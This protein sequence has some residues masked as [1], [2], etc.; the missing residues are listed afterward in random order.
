MPT[1]PLPRPLTARPF[2]VSLIVFGLAL[3]WLGGMLVS[4][5]G[6]A[7][8]LV[9]GTATVGSGLLAWRGDRRGAYLYAAMLVGTFVWA[10]GEVGFDPWPLMPRLLAPIVLG[11]GFPLLGICPRLSRRQRLGAAG[12]VVVA[13]ALV[14]IM[15][16]RFDPPSVDRAPSLQQRGGE[17]TEAS[18]WPAY[19]RDQG[20]TRYS[21]LTQLTPA[22]VSA[23]QP[24]WQYRTGYV[25]ESVRTTFEATPLKIGDSLYF[26]SPDNDIIALDATTGVQRWRYRM[27]ADQDQVF[28]AAC[29]GVTYFRNPAQQGGLCTAAIISGTIDGRLFALDAATGTPCPRFGRGGFVDLKA[30]LGRVEKGYYFVTSAPQLI[31]GKVVLGGWVTDNQH[32]GEPSGVIRAFDAATGAFAWA[33][34]MGRPNDHGMP[35]AGQR[36]TPGT[37]NSW[38]P[39][40]ADETLGLVYLPTGNA[41]PD[42]FGGMRRPFDEKY[43][44]SVVALNADTGAV[45][46]SFQT[47]HHDLWDYDVPSQPTL[48]DMPTPSGRVPAVIQAT[49][50]GEIF[51]LDRR[52]GRPITRVEERPA[53]KSNVPGER[54]APTQPFSTGMP[55]FAGPDLTEAAMWG[56]TPLDQAW[57]RILFRR[58]RYDGPVTPVGL[59]RPTIISPGYTGGMNWGGVSIDRQRDI[60]IVNSMRVAVR[61]QLIPR[62]QADRLGVKAIS[63]D[64][65]GDVG[66]TAAQAG[67][68]YAVKLAPFLSPL[69]IPCQ[70]PPYGMISA[71]DLKTRKLLWSHP[72]G[73]GREAGPFGIRSMLPFTMGVPNIGGSITTGGGVTFIGAA[74]DSYF[75]A[76]DTQ[77]GQLLWR[78]R[79]PAGGQATPM[80]Y[81]GRD[82]HQI[83]VIAAGG[84]DALAARRGD[85]VLAF[86]LP[87]QDRR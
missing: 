54:V 40:S 85:Y 41:T 53:P 27:R 21:S 72:F 80:T 37:P 14:L 63:A 10:I 9:A 12:T 49:K 81:R 16:S 68:P 61:S 31:R 22:N 39:I 32:L 34:D 86:A 59:D 43:S 18:D 66:G 76:Y 15:G 58:S 83:I 25:Q 24:L 57:C 8:Y 56:V 51:V 65:H 20:G 11:L 30:G 79:L 13:V 42:W 74:Q 7:Y 52:T 5:G 87:S 44:S 48:Y 67:T 70:Q 64:V 28:L 35:P 62:H 26:C 78:T 19:G 71:I 6:S 2:A 38:A 84:H 82:G 55:S 75:R 47:T 60:M 46:W 77:T 17:K 1:P 29:R 23:L 4:V 36:F 50:R 3:C 73:T 33:F 45:R 69:G